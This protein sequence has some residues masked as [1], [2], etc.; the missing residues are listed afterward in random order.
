MTYEVRALG[1]ADVD[2]YR[3]VRLEALRLHPEAF[4]ADYDEAAHRSRAVRRPSG[5]AGHHPVRRI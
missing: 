2:E 5:H 1:A 3:R 4:G